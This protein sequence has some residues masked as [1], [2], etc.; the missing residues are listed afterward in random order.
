M[1]RGALAE[2]RRRR[3]ARA[4]LRRGIQTEPL[5]KSGVEPSRAPRPRG[6]PRAN[7]APGFVGAPSPG[8]TARSTFALAPGRRAGG[9]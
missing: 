7:G 9:D 1:A 3:R 6:A 2:A 4:W 8:S 5:R